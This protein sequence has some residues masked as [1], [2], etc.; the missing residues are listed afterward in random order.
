MDI[1]FSFDV[2]L[3]KEVS[4]LC[5]VLCLKY[6]DHL[7]ASCNLTWLIFVFS[8][9]FTREYACVLYTYTVQSFR[10]TSRRLQHLGKLICFTSGLCFFI[11]SFVCSSFLKPVFLHIYSHLNF[12]FSFR[13]DCKN[14]YCKKE[15]RKQLSLSFSKPNNLGVCVCYRFSPEFS[16]LT[17]LSLLKSR[18]KQRWTHERVPTVPRRLYFPALQ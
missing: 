18:L 13:V 17:T 3:E 8:C 5:G 11:T 1:F 10:L 14:K 9:V 16:G 6:R 12:M 15:N 4:A 7:K 2:F